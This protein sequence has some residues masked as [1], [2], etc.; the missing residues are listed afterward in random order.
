MMVLTK[1]AQAG[2]SPLKEHPGD[3]YDTHPVAVHALLK[4]ERLPHRIWEPACGKG[5][6]VRVLR[7]AGHHVIASDI[8]RRGCPNA[9]LFD[10][11]DERVPYAYDC[12]CVLTNPPYSLAERFVSVALERAPL[13]IMLLRLAFLESVK[14]SE[15]L[16]TGLLSKVHV[17]SNRLPMM[18]RDNWQGKRASSA[19]PFAWFVWDLNHRG[20]ITVDRIRWQKDQQNG[21]A[22]TTEVEEGRS[23]SARI[24]RY[25]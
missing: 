12:D 16:D 7:R 18:H 9:S 23:T 6:I 14:R 4:V 3:L 24:R 2:R 10:F 22:R 17:F 25:R 15:L 19:I 11:L 5:N 8:K 21:M 20:P 1:R 13:V